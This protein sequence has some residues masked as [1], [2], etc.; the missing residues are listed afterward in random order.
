MLVGLAAGPPL[1]LL[2]LVKRPVRVRADIIPAPLA[3]EEDGLPLDHDL[4]RHAHGAKALVGGGA[5][6]LGLRQRSVLP[7]E[8]VQVCLDL[9][10]LARR[11][12]LRRA[13]RG[14]GRS[15]RA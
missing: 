3:A 14:L 8:L 11:W 1:Q 10:L 2:D 15:A 4:D 7:G 12:W 9:G 6:F 13:R 5:V